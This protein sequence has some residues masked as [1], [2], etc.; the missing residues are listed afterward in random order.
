M[1]NRFADITFNPDYSLDE[2]LLPP[3]DSLTS[4]VVIALLLLCE[5]VFLLPRKLEKW[6]PS[7]H[8]NIAPAVFVSANDVF[9]YA[10][11][12]CEH[13]P[14]SEDEESDDFKSFR[15]YY[16]LIRLHGTSGHYVWLIERRR[17]QPIPRIVKRLKEEGLWH[18][19]YDL[20]YSPYVKQET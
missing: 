5:H 18:R 10:T 7:L 6:D 12:D 2:N 9:Y 19:E 8:S 13:L 11:A 20:F 3:F 15:H 4:E 16:E 17:Q 14:F 1:D